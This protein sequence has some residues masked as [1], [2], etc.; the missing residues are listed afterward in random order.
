MGSKSR[1]DGMGF[2]S[3]IPAVAVV[4]R[5][6][7]WIGICN[8]CQ[9]A[10]LVEG[11]GVRVFPAPQPSP[12]DPTIPSKLRRDLDEAKM[13]ASVS[14]FQAA[15]VMARRCIQ[16]ACIEKGC[17]PN[18]RLVDQIAALTAQ[19]HITKDIEEWATVVRFMG[20]DGAHPGNDVVGKDEAMDCLELA[21][22][23]LY[24]LFVTPALAKQRLAARKASKK[25]P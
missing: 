22:Q 4:D 17:D 8:S 11:Q 10:V 5:T 13:C 12:S 1:H 18:K 23:F 7:W 20:N 2:T 19:G 24:V 16:L 25:S 15:A 9:M 6:E 3:E 21:E 14:C